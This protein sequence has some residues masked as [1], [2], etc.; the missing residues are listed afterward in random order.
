MT[1]DE[2][3]SVGGPGVPG[4]DDLDFDA[5]SARSGAKWAR[6]A[7][8][9][10]APAWVADMDF[11]VAPPIARALHE[12]VDRSDLGYPD[13]FDGTPLRE[14]FAQRMHTRY[15][16][17]PDPGAVREQTDLIQALQLV[18]HLSTTRGDAV[19][20][21]TPNYPPFL[22][23]LRRMGL[24][25]IDFPFVDRGDGWV[26][27][28]D[29]F[30]PL[31]ARRRPR[32]LVLVNPHNPTGRV[33]TR[34]ELERIA[35]LAE[36]FDMLVVSDEIHAELLYEPHRHIPFASLGPETAARTVT[37]TSA[38]KAFNLAGMRCA[39]VHY[40]SETLLKRRD[41]EPFDLYGTV[42]VPGVVATLAAWREGDAWQRDLLQ[43]LDRNRRRVDEVLRERIPDLRHHLPQGTYLTWLNTGP[44]GIDDPVSTVRERGRVL[45]DG[46]VRFGSGARN[47]LR[48]NFA[49][50]GPILDR[51]L[52]GIT[53]AL[54][55]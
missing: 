51:I 54:G 7:A 34:E 50:S 23:S 30:E 32:V 18:L 37:L 35:D 11:P 2:R 43:V 49:T 27:D 39:V 55:A 26:L 6:A 1:R 3:L 28:F 38:S 5:L 13:W 46:G 52:D 42:S 4:F 20:I 41:A 24:Q 10:L 47:F 12:L 14:E 21:Q 25:Q 44:L 8:D 17:E 53:D 9:G 36:R 48:I 40:G 29:T 19:A 45:A 16:W 22:A 31:V 15:G 33:L